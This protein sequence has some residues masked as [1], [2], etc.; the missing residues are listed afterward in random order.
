MTPTGTRLTLPEELID[1]L[2]WHVER[3]PDGPMKGLALKMSS[4]LVASLRSAPRTGWL[5]PARAHPP[6]T[7]GSRAKPL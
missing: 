4:R 7:P 5:F 1:V 2:R 3:L 6:R